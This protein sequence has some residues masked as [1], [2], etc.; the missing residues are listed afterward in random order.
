[1]IDGLVL[2]EMSPGRAADSLRLSRLAGWNQTLRDWEFLLSEGTGVGFQTREGDIVAS[3]VALPLGPRHGWISMV[4]TDP[5][6]RRRGL[7]KH[8]MA[9]GIGLL[10]ERGLIPTLD[11]TPAG[12]TVYRG[13]G[14]SGDTQLA[15]WKVTPDAAPQEPVSVSRVTIREIDED[16]LPSLATWD[17]DHSGCDRAAILRFLQANRPELALM[18]ETSDGAPLGYIMG[19]S[20]DRLPQ[21]GPLVAARPETARLLLNAAAARTGGAFYVDAFDKTQPALASGVKAHWARERGFT[22]LMKATGNSPEN[23]DTVTLAAGPELS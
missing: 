18:A 7:A 16:D 2:I 17:L 21:I 12:E 10:E 23:P 9:R 4:L 1:M 15:R 13:I 3:M 8:L 20:G 19:R 14:F 11:A 22:R 6:W 5:D